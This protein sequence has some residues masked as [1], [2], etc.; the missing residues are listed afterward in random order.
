MIKHIVLFKLKD[1]LSEEEK[2]EI[3]D[4]FR[5]A[6]E[7]LPSVIPSIRAI[8]VRPNLNPVESWD[9]CLDSAFDTLED[10]DAYS[11]NPAH[12]AA[13]SILKNVK[14]DRA[15]VDYEV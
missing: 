3:T 7:A 1:N 11:I 6:I 5:N 15:C 2:L 12:V 4:N 13:A 9:I 14:Q 8:S 10:V